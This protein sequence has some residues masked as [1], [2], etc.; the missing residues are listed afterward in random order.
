MPPSLYPSPVERE[1]GAFSYKPDTPSDKCL[2][3]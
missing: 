2:K 3:M 1:E